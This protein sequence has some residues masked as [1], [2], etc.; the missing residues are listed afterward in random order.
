[1]TGSKDRKKRRDKTFG[2][3]IRAK[4]RRMGYS[5][6]TIGL[7]HQEARS[8]DLVLEAGMHAKN[9]IQGGPR[10]AVTQTINHCLEDLS[11]LHNP[12]SLRLHRMLSAALVAATRGWRYPVK[13]V[14]TTSKAS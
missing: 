7:M 1:M 4:M 9:L 14:R 13:V 6:E 8:M 2:A 11:D 12:R 5:N 10:E 3:R